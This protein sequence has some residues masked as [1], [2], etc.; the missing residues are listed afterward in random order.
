MATD[1]GCHPKVLCKSNEMHFQ[2]LIIDAG[3]QIGYPSLFIK[4]TGG[5]IFYYS[6]YKL[7]NSNSFMINWFVSCHTLPCCGHVYKW[8]R[9]HKKIVDKLRIN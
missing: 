8:G 4:I 5:P 7:D 9:R 3:E 6:L 2:G 1:L